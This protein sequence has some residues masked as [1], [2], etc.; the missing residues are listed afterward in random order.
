MSKSRENR[1]RRARRRKKFEAWNARR[2]TNVI[3]RLIHR[4]TGQW[5][6][7]EWPGDG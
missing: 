4:V 1:R 6:G 7:D 3:K 2:W 5:P